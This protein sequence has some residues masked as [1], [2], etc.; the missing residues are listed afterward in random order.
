M[1]I[2][3]SNSG[4][5]VKSK[6]FEV[7]LNF[8]N[9]K[10]GHFRNFKK[11]RQKYNFEKVGKSPQ[12]PLDTWLT[13]FFFFLFLSFLFFFFSTFSL[14]PHASFFFFLPL[15]LALTDQPPPTIGLLHM[16][17]KHT[18]RMLKPLGAAWQWLNRRRGGTC[19]MCDGRRF[20]RT[21][22]SRTLSTFTTGSWSQIAHLNFFFKIVPSISD[23]S[24]YIIG[25][26]FPMIEPLHRDL[27]QTEP[28]F[29]VTILN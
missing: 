13:P 25:M 29:E 1:K 4:Q 20:F 27:S 23:K 21:F 15:F 11:P 12:S 19:K 24:T 16:L 7:N 17:A 3:N 22:K 28:Y 14:L 5:I 10:L 9:L 8:R 6:K 2:W 18:Q 26:H